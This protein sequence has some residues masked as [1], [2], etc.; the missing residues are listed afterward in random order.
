MITTTATVT[1]FVGFR[2]ED[3]FLRIS[4]RF[5]PSYFD[6][7]L[8]NV[9][10][11]TQWAFYI[12]IGTIESLGYGQAKKCHSYIEYIQ[13]HAVLHEVLTLR[14]TKPSRHL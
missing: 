11:F 14:L 1:N 6:I 3:L 4:R 10:V 2:H 8:N 13:H 12:H 7:M 9:I 5:G